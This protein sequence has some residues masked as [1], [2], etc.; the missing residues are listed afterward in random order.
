MVDGMRN[1][2]RTFGTTN[3]VN[4]TI[5]GAENT[6]IALNEVNRIMNSLVKGEEKHELLVNYPPHGK[7]R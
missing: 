4:N 1:K 7:H 6:F 3:E 2:N 5:Q